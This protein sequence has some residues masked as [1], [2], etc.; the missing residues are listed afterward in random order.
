MLTSLDRIDDLIQLLNSPEPLSA[1]KRKELYRSFLR[2]V[3]PKML[4]D[5]TNGK[6]FKLTER[7]RKVCAI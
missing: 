4:E 2:Q 6:Y 3:V 1:K 5:G 7:A